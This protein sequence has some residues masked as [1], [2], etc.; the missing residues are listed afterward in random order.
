MLNLKSTRNIVMKK[1]KSNKRFKDVRTWGFSVVFF[2][3][4]LFLSP[5]AKGT[6]VVD[7]IVAIVNEDIITLSEL[8]EI[9]KPYEEKIFSLEYPEEQEKKLL[10]KVREEKLNLMIE[11]RLAD[12]EIKKMDITVGEAEIDGTIER[13]KKANFLTDETMREALAREGSSYEKLR[14]QIKEQILRTRLVHYKIKSKIVITE[15]DM[16]AYYDKKSDTYGGAINYYLKNIYMSVSSSDIEAKKKTLRKMKKVLKELKKGRP[17]EDAAREYSESPYAHKGGDLG[18][19]ELKELAPQIRKAVQDL[20]PGEH[21]QVIDTEQGYQIFLVKDISRAGGV[22][23]ESVAAEIEEK[24]YND[25]VDEKYSE[26]I[27]DLRKN[28][29]IKIIN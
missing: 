14:E 25:I 11:Q 21:T 18:R 16:K 24:L 15:E 29:H 12:Q 3:T 7:R 20:K 1:E 10:F 19:F 28:S 26:W 6:E 2:L 13:I 23:F 5:L 8:K 9:L 27:R 22:S 4:L 17:F